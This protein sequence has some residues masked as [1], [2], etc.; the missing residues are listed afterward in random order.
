MMPAVIQNPVSRNPYAAVADF[1]S[2]TCHTPRVSRSSSVLI[3]LLVS[4][5]LLVAAYWVRLPPLAGAAFYLFFAVE[6]DLRTSRIPNWLNASGLL[7]ALVLAFALGG[8]AAVGGAGLGAV[9][10]LLPALLLYRVGLLGAGDAKG[11]AV[12]GSLHGPLAVP[13]LYIWMLLA[14][15]LLSMGMLGV[16]GELGAFFRRWGRTLKVLLRSRRFVHARP[17][18]GSAAAGGIPFALCMAFG[19]FAQWFWGSP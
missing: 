9:I 14:G 1:S 17:E 15:A 19:S 18:A 8:G 10:A 7:G 12:L 4:A 13:G 16:R 11:I 5:S 2:T 6:Y 3:A